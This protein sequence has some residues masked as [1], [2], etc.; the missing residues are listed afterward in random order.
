MTRHIRSGPERILHWLNAAAILILMGSG[1]EIFRADPFYPLDIPPALTLG[2]DLTAALRLHFAAMWLCT[3]ATI[4]L[5]LRRLLPGRAV[6][7]RPL[8][9]RGVLRDTTAALRGRLGHDLTAYNH[10]QRLLYSGVF[11]LITASALSGLAIWKPVQ[12]APLT[13]LLGGYEAARRVHFWAMAAIG[14][15]VLLHVTM[16]LLVP[17]TLAAMLFGLTKTES[18]P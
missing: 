18:K 11:A 15:F 14:A 13:D 7:L 3:F 8:N 9:P 1:W 16:A 17:R 4:T 10:V 2:D 5:L 12:L 6:P